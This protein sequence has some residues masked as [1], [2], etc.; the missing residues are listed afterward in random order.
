MLFFNGWCLVDKDAPQEAAPEVSP[1][2]HAVDVIAT[3][4][5]LDLPAGAPDGD[6]P[7]TVDWS[8]SGD[9]ERWVESPAPGSP[10]RAAAPPS[11]RR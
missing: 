11:H 9:H 5:P 3:L 8:K 7:P 6:L 2:G 4:P 1:P 10:A